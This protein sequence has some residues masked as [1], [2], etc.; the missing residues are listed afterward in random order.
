MRGYFLAI[1]RTF[2]EDAMRVCKIGDGLAVPLPADVVKALDLKEGDS[3]EV[4]T[5]ADK[6]VIVE[7]LQSPAE[8]IEALRKHRGF[9]PADYKF[10]RDEA[11]ERR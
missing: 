5:S 3:V 8:M 10:D 11:N 4:R 2:G 7:R 1:Y 9:I 6:Q